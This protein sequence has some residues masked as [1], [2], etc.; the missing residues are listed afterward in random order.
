MLQNLIR[1]PHKHI[2]LSL[3]KVFARYVCTPVLIGLTRLGPGDEYVWD[4]CKRE[5][6]CLFQYT[7]AGQGRFEDLAQGREYRLRPGQGFLVESPSPTRYWLQHGD[8]WEFMFML[9]VGDMAFCHSREII[10]RHGYVH[11]LAPKS[12]PVER[13]AALYRAALPEQGLDKYT[14]SSLLY[15]F[16]MGMLRHYAQAGADAPG[17]LQRARKLAQTGYGEAGLGVGDMARAAGYS[18]YHFSRLFKQRMGVSPYAYLLEVR[19][20][21]ALERVMLENTPLKRIAAEV[22]F[23]DYSYF[24]N[25]FKQHHGITPARARR[26]AR[27]LGVSDVRG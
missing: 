4:N 19:L 24:S 25:M 17:P 9:Y 1:L 23:C 8:A 10:A 7:L 22:G 27:S 2:Q 16:L 26:Q 15:Q 11:D 13:V 14:A 21:A 12:M 6:F 3:R 20:Q 5:K 18:R